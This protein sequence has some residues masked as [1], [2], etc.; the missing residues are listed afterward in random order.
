MANFGNSERFYEV[1]W[2][3]MATVL[4]TA[5]YLTACSADADDLAQETMLK[6]FK[7]LDRL[8]PNTNTKAWLLTILRHSHID[9]FR[10]RSR[11]ETSIEQIE[12][13][14]A[15]PVHSESCEEDVS[16]K[17][18]E[19]V[20][21]ELSDQHIVD[22]LHELPKEIRWTL[23]LSDIEGLEEA[24]AAAVLGV[25]LGTIKSRLHRGRQMLRQSLAPMIQKMRMR[26]FRRNAVFVSSP[27]AP[28]AQ[29]A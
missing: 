9:S 21:N 10:A 19:A 5:T 23:L 25:P 28:S 24:D 16:W 29:I 1:V 17:D 6:A 7:S 18:P 11:N 3:H 4:R 22:A 15:A 13:E 14:P 2:P 8:Q 20:L 12:Y 27:L 26:A